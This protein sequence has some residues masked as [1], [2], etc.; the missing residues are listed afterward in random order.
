MRLPCIFE[1]TNEEIYDEMNYLCPS[2]ESPYTQH[3]HALKKVHKD[4]KINP[5]E[6]SGLI[7]I[8]WRDLIYM[9]N[10]FNLGFYSHIKIHQ[11]SSKPVIFVIVCHTSSFKAIINEVN[12]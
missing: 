1:N 9:M 5:Y 3:V 10:R 6:S 2:V 7:Q 11:H 12:E 4:V 8:F